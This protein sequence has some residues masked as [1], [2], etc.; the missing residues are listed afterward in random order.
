MSP[1]LSCHL[2]NI[3]HIPYADFFYCAYKSYVPGLNEKGGGGDGGA[4]GSGLINLNDAI[5]LSDAAGSTHSSLR[6][7]KKQ[8]KQRIT[9]CSTGDPGCKTIP[10]TR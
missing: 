3:K 8:K 4:G 2:K 5:S 10:D 6:W 1:V 7:Q 9:N